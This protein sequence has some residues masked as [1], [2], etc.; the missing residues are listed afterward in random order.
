MK[1]QPAANQRLCGCNPGRKYFTSLQDRKN[2]LLLVGDFSRFIAGYYIFA[3]F[4]FT[5]A[6]T[7]DGYCRRKKTGSGRTGCSGGGLN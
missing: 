7:V 1:Q 6:V 4:F 2:G 3:L 5:P